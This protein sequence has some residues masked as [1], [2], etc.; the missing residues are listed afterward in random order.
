[1][2]DE[3]RTLEIYGYISDELKPHSHKRVVAVCEDCGKYRDVIYAQ[4]RDLCR[5]CSFVG[6]RNHRYGK[7]HSDETRRKISEANRG[8]RNYGYGKHLSEEH[9]K[10]L[11]E[12][13]IGDNNPNYGKSPS[14]ETRKKSSIARMGIR[15]SDDHKKK[16]SAARQGIQY[17]EWEKFTKNSLYCPSF[18]EACKESNREKYGRRC[19]I[20]G[21]PESKNT[22]STGIQKKLSVHHIDM[23]KNQG[24]DG[25]RWKLI[26]V[27]M[28]HH[29]HNGLWTARFVYLLNNVWC[30]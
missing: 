12:S 28:T 23:N 24:C 11:S 9:K 22:T 7:H 17:D 1:M 15:F 18:N 26:P 14:E 13:K 5:P 29:Y 21:L 6:D 25:I 27:C 10:K 30:D 2:I 16:I 8:E 3:S 19:F 20:C 4:Y